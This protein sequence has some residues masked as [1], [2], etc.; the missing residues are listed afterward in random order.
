MSWEDVEQCAK[1]SP[2]GA[3]C[4]L[5]LK[6]RSTSHTRLW[7]TI[8]AAL[9]ERLGWQVGQPLVLQ[10]GRGAHAGQVRILPRAGG[11][12]LRKLPRSSL[13]NIELSVPEDLIPWEGPRRVVEH[14]VLDDG[15]LFCTLPWELPMDKRGF[16]LPPAAVG[17]TG[18]AGADDAAEA[19]AA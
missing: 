15:V 9:R 11:R 6:A 1:D 3:P 12:L 16:V 13:T 17:E 18:E 5:A 14:Q 8:N 2:I 19:E 7:C 10:I 4:T